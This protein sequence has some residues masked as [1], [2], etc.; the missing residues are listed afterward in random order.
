MFTSIVHRSYSLSVR[1]VR[2]FCTKVWVSDSQ[3]NSSC[4]LS[5]SVFVGLQMRSVDRLDKTNVRLGLEKN[6]KV[7]LVLFSLC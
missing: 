6:F 7:V 1:V 2:V 4:H 5:V 3:S